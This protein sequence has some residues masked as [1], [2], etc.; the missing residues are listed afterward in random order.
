MAKEILKN[1]EVENLESQVNLALSWFKWELNLWKP[2]IHAG[3]AGKEKAWDNG[4]ELTVDKMKAQLEAT[5]LRI[6]EYIKINGEK[7]KCTDITVDEKNKMYKIT[8][9]VS[10]WGKDYAFP[11]YFKVINTL[12]NSY[13]EFQIP[14]GKKQSA[15]DIFLDGKVYDVNVVKEKTKDVDI[16]IQYNE[17]KT[18]AKILEK[19]D[20]FALAKDFKIEK[21][22][23]LQNTQITSLN[24]IQLWKEIVKTTNGY[25][26]SVFLSENRKYRELG[27]VYFDAKWEIDM[28]QTASNTEFNVF[29]VPLKLALDLKKNIFKIE[30]TVDL[31]KKIQWHREKLQA[32]VSNSSVGDNTIFEWF[33]RIWPKRTK[34]ENIWLSLIDNTYTVQRGKKNE[35]ILRFWFDATDKLSLK[36]L[37]WVSVE[38]FVLPVEV[39]DETRLYD[40]K[41]T[42]S[43]LQINES[44]ETKFQTMKELPELEDAPSSLNAKN[45]Y[46]YNRDETQQLEYFDAEGKL[47]AAIPSS[48]TE[49]NEWKLWTLS[50]DVDK[51]DLFKEYV[52]EFPSESLKAMN[53]LENDL[54]T[55]FSNNEDLNQITLNKRPVVKVFE[56]GKY[57]YYIV[58]QRKAWEQFVF[59]KDDELYEEAKKAI[60]LLKMNLQVLEILSKTEL[61]YRDG[62]IEGDFLK[63]QWWTGWIGLLD[64]TTADK[65]TF[66]ATW[67]KDE[68]SLARTLVYSNGLLNG[69]ADVKPLNFI[70]KKD[71]IALEGK[72]KNE[73]TIELQKFQIRSE[74][75]K[76]QFTL[77]FDTIQ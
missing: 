9:T 61:K 13:I 28:E 18:T 54:Y 59:E 53:I 2:T 3:P 57:R 1:A 25:Y 32:F 63:F 64:V 52:N 15:A 6:N 56:W 20:A 44:K 41:T 55:I 74:F 16:R 42:E 34:T 77:W 73:V 45:L 68:K 40:V 36:D 49:T 22:P 67:R 11:S 65:L 39:D 71:D 70:I 47:I 8:Y 46:V 4:E 69:G 29:D 76:G 10:L 66:L 48:K 50:Q 19:V 58:D 60:D 62:K 24:N 72:K 35:D 26:R 12:N 51:Y 21:D 33:N 5:K 31:I 14:P 38:S 27:K 7:I 30:K 17:Q 75:T 43:K 23:K 37:K